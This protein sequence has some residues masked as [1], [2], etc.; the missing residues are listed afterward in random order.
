MAAVDDALAYQQ[1]QI[2]NFQANMPSYQQSIF[3]GIG[4]NARSGVNSDFNK[5]DQNYNDRGLLY[6]GIKDQAKANA[7]ADRA[8]QA[9]SDMATANNQLQNEDYQHQV[10]GINS[11]INNYN[12]I[13]QAGLAKYGQEMQ[14]NAQNRQMVGG[15]L[16]GAGMA[17][18]FSDKNMKKNIESGDKD[19]ASFL[20]KIP[21]KKY[22]YKDEKNGEGKQFGLLAQDLEKHPVGKAMVIETPEGKAVDY[23]KGLATILAT[24]SF[25]HKKLKNI[26][27]KKESA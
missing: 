11:G 2:R 10:S 19:V 13:N 5:I 7:A 18:A 25:L 8:G 24:Q 14:A 21:S 1:E 15:L 4:E 6:S 12:G 26:E 20:D 23:G 22:D 17:L 9:T 3:A 27:S 16:G